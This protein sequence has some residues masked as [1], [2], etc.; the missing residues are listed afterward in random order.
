MEAQMASRARHHE[1]QRAPAAPKWREKARST[2]G[3]DHLWHHP[4]PPAR[5]DAAA[6]AVPRRTFAQS[7]RA[8]T[9]LR[10]PPRRAKGVSET[11]P[12]S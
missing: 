10:A 11:P 5:I 12:S 8:A 9:A 4:T 2:L 6:L 3:Q 7:P 1:A